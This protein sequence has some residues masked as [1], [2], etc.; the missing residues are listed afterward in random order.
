MREL[1]RIDEERKITP[2]YERYNINKD[3]FEALRQLLLIIANEPMPPTVPLLSARKQTQR[4]IQRNSFL[5]RQSLIAQNNQLHL[6][7]LQQYA[8]VTSPIQSARQYT[9]EKQPFQ[10]SVAVPQ[11]PSSVRSHQTFQTNQYSQSQSSNP[12]SVRTP[13]AA[14][15]SMLSTRSERLGAKAVFE[16]KQYQTP[17]LLKIS[18][19]EFQ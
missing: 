8:S 18:L 12:G 19:C 6:S 14:N 17:Q 4:I 16:A 10:I 11:T 1:N 3:V 13:L 5:Q 9:K 7:L 15:Y 2:G